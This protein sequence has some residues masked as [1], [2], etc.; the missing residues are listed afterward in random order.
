MT[1]KEYIDNFKLLSKHDKHQFKEMM[2]ILQDGKIVKW[3]HGERKSC[4]S[5]ERTD[6]LTT[7]PN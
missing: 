6:T 7:E 2:Y 1:D 5:V 4:L 3:G